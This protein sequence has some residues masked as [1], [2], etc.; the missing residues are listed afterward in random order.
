MTLFS[1]I[2]LDELRA[3][4]ATFAEERDWG[5]FHQPRNLV[6]ALVG[7]VGEVSECFQWRGEC[8][9]GLPGWSARDREHLGEELSDVLLYLVRL[10][11]RCGIDLA[12]AAERKMALNRAK[13][14]AALARGSSAKYTAYE[15]T[16]LTAGAEGGAAPAPELTAGAEGGAAPAPADAV[17]PKHSPT[18]PKAGGA[19]AFSAEVVPRELSY[20]S[21][22]DKSWRFIAAAVVSASILS[23][24][25][26]FAARKGVIRR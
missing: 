16:K 18:D 25:F 4:M 1:R 11:D 5:Q 24:T 3:A 6:L 9:P 10:A 8:L 19:G 17:T 12:A 13:Y 14:P 23:A 22:E 2:T 20:G 26:Y 15:G 21:G 7:E